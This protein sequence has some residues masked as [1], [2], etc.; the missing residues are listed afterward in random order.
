MKLLKEYQPDIIIS[1]HPF[2]SQMVSYLKRKALI[3][4]K[5]ATILTDFAPHEQWLVGANYVDYFFVSHEKLRQELINTGISPDKVFA[6][7]IPLS[8]R[9]YYIITKKKLRILLVSTQI[10]S[11]FVLWWRSFWIRT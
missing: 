6:T 9:F 10:K 3:D 4:C 2:A 1:T 7:G 8:Y 11:Y 5:L